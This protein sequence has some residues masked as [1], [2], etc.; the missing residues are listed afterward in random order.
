MVLRDRLRAG[1]GQSAIAE[2][3]FGLVALLIAALA[4]Y[5]VRYLTAVQLGVTT[6]DARY[7][8]LAESF[9]RGQPY[10]IISFP[11]AP[12]E[13]VFPPGYPLFVLAPAALIFGFNYALLRAV[14]IIL[15]LG[16]VLLT[17]ALVKK[18]LPTRSATL[19][20]TAMFALNHVVAGLAGMA[21]S[22]PAFMFFLLLHLVLL[23]WWTERGGV[24]EPQIGFLLVLALVMAAA[25]LTRYQGLAL[26]AAS[27]VYLLAQRR[28]RQAMIL[29]VAFLLPMLA[30]VAVR[31]LMRQFATLWQ[32]L[33]ST[34]WN[35]MTTI[36]L[37][38][39]PALGPRVLAAF[40]AI[41]LG[42]VVYSFHLA[43]F[44]CTAFGVIRGLVRGKLPAIYAVAY[45][46][47][48]VVIDNH[49]GEFRNEARYTAAM[50]PFLYLYFFK[51]L[52]AIR[53]LFR[54]ERLAMHHV[55][56]LI[57]I[58]FIVVLLLRNVQQGRSVFP[59][60]DLSAGASWVQ[61]HTAEDDIIMTRD[62]LERYLYL[63]RRTVS[64]SSAAYEGLMQARE[65][66]PLADYVLIAP[67]LRTQ[68]QQPNLKRDLDTDDAT[69][70]LPAIQADPKRFRLV[71]HDSDARAYLY[72]IATTAGGP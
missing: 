66:Q 10:R 25:V 35:Y 5:V 31:M 45:F 18:H 65:H 22:E 7:M 71:W 38:M 14:S 21:M 70:L 47:L 60:P 23:Q 59:V 48:I 46:A 49:G 55:R 36:P 24:R 9:L 1:A 44:S 67:P 27:V 15:T 53:R 40:T 72:E 63:R 68:D 19:L 12:L 20:V 29:T 16:N 32:R 6:D 56:Q 41:G 43:L 2:T 69:K 34:L 64:L 62:P 54:V 26:V 17:Y 4:L 42:W 58:G 57:G 11:D 13:T 30:F 33:P 52:L 8:V 3:D 50:L 51:S 61:A 37:V 28:A 39:L